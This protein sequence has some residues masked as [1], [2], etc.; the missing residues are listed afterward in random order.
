[1]GA[2]GSLYQQ[3]N[4]SHGGIDAYA[5]AISDLYQDL[6]GEGSFTGKGIY[7]VDAFAAALCGS[8]CPTTPC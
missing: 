3:L 8:E 1:M 5:A 7:D 2:E 6:F 4:A